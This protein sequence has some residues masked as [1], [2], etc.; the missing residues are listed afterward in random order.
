MYLS[1][2]LQGFREIV[3]VWKGYRHLAS[4]VL[5]THFGYSKLDCKIKLTIYVL[6]KSLV[7]STQFNRAETHVRNNTNFNPI[8]SN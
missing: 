4:T 5:E 8:N 1:F 3:Y 6:T 7:I 2:V